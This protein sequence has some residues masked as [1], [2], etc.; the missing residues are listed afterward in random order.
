MP[1]FRPRSDLE[2]ADLDADGLVAHIRAARE[3]GDAGQA[4]L[5]LRMVVY[6]HLRD[7]ERRVALKVPA[8]DVEEVA[9]AAFES[10]FKAA[11]D[12]TSVGEF[13]ALLNRIVD[14]RVADYHRRRPPRRVPLVDGDGE[15][16]VESE[17]GRIE[18]E[19]AVEQALGEL[20]PVH[21]AVVERVVFS[22][23][24][25]PAHVVAGEVNAALAPTPPMSATN[26]HQIA[27][28]FR[29]RLREL[30]GEGDT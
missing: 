24:E 17:S 27:S 15:P 11:F 10:A 19:S 30:L 21:R 9:G 23:D 14:R 22:A 1:P 7:V 16:G 12:G 26:V 2:L 20:N 18:V 3:A 5:A 25:P 8:E 4:R 6:T 29:A 13:R 28:R